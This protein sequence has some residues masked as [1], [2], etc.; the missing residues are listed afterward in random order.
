MPESAAPNKL[1]RKRTTDNFGRRNERRQVMLR[2]V[3]VWNSLP[4]SFPVFPDAQ[5]Q[6]GQIAQLTISGNMVCCGVSNGLSPIGVIDDQKVRAF[7]AAAWDEA[8]VTPPILNPAVNGSNQLVLPYD[9]KL[10]LNNPNVL[11]Q[12]FVSIPV[13]VALIPRNGVVCIPAGTLLNYDLLG[14]GT[15]NAV[16][17]LVRYSYQIPNI[18][19][20][21]STWASQRVT[22]WMTRF[23][24]A[25]D[26]FATTEQYPVNSNL[27]VDEWGFFTTRQPYPNS[28]AVAITIGPPSVIDATLEF[29]WL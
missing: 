29:L 2:L 5:F 9:I 6:S 25:T 12:S 28:P 22:V 14:T 11:P 19:G 20:D 23:I 1:H 16:K 3:A 18:I 8:V 15:P 13:P 26:C 10:E 17:T 21:D 24:G 27:F 7:S 4:W